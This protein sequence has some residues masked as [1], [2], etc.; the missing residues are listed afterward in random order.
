[1]TKEQTE[2]DKSEGESKTQGRSDNRSKAYG[3]MSHVHRTEGNK[4]SAIKL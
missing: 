1:M 3:D 2:S 4:K